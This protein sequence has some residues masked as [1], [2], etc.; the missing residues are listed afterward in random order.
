MGDPILHRIEVRG[1]IRPAKRLEGAHR[2][3]ALATHLLALLGLLGL[4]SQ[5]LSA[6]PLDEIKA[7]NLLR[8]VAYDDNH[9]FSW[10]EAGI[11]KGIDVDI[12]RAIAKKLSVDVEVILR[13]QGEKVDDDLRANIWRGPLTGGALGDVMIHVPID[14][15][16][17]IRNKEAVMGN[18]YFEERVAIAV[19]PART[20]DNPG[21]DIFKREKIAVQLGTVADYFLM[22]FDGGALRPNINHYIKPRDGIDS[23]LRK[24]VAGL[25]GVRSHLEGLFNQAG[26]KAAFIE[27]PMP[28]IVRSS[29][30]V[31]IAVKENSRDLYYSIGNILAEMKASG[32]LTAIFD[33]YGVTYIPP[34]VK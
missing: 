26:Q 7:G 16:L 21:L 29:W 4:L 28:G 33:R 15:E 3:A 30:T 10:S 11:A 19:D 12:G 22:F 17:V 23:F 8:V 14:K 6:R 24:E 9:P 31:G 13:M 20:G 32:E 18:P 2:S 34:T 1:L 25:M 5:A 27:P